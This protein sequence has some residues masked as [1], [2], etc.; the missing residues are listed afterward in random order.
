MHRCRFVNSG[1]R[2]TTRAVAL[3]SLLVAALAAGAFAQPA[4]PHHGFLGGPWEVLVKMG[5]EGTALR[6]PLS[7]ADENKPQDLTGVIPVAGTPLQVKLE[8]Y[9]PDLKRETTAVEDP[10]GGPAARLS[11]RGESLQQDLWLCTRDRERQSISAHIGGVAIRELPSD[12]S[13]L[14][15]LTEREAVGVL[16]I[17]LS[18]TSDPL[19][20]TVKPGRVVAL[21]GSPWKL[22]ILRYVP[23][24]SVN[25]QTKEVTSLS[26]KPENPALEVRVEGNQQEFRQWL[27]S[28]FSLAPH[29]MQQLPFR[30]RFLDFH[31]TGAGQYIL[32]AVPGPRPYLLSLQGGKKHVEQVELGQRYPFNDKR[33]SFAVEE[34]RSRAKIETTWKNG[35]E[36]LLHP[37]VVA[38]IAQGGSAQPVVLELGQPC[39]QKT[40][41]GTLV[42]LYRRVP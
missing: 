12:G 36:M 9:L 25:R 24:Y 8:R 26:D 7:I 31:L 22:S 32:A 28:Q 5:L 18:E 27:W 38:T 19:A 15:E 16:L 35:S 29:K 20:Y 30:A 6:L 14:Q 2:R 41:V 39:H 3:L 37:A 1:M 40:S 34:M 13:I 11:L 4:S 33:Y 42:V 21:P 23:H 17:W 10:N